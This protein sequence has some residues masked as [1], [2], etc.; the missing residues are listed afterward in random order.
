[1]WC[2]Q[3]EPMSVPDTTKISDSARAMRLRMPSGDAISCAHTMLSKPMPDWPL[4]LFIQSQPAGA[5]GASN[6][7]ASQGR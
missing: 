4:R 5:R 3:L 1:M 2:G 7:C 6:C